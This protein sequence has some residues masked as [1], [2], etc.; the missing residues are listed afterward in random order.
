MYQWRRMT[1]EQRRESLEQRQRQRLP[2]HGP[3]H[4]ESDSHIYLITAAC[5]EH[6]HFIGYSTSRMADFE[7]ELLRTTEATCKQIFAWVVLPNHYHLLVETIDLEGLLAA[8]GKLHGRTS[9][10]WNQEED[11]F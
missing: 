1:P 5:Y 11:A 10:G 3:P 8:L 2:W 4:Y 9:Y 7:A 6:Q